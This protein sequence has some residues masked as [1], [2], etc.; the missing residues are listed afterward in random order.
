MKIKLVVLLLLVSL[1]FAPN[2]RPAHATDSKA[3]TARCVAGRT[4]PATGFW[5]W[6]ANSQVNVYL[7]EPD[8]SAADL[9][10]VEIAVQNWDVTA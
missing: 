6:P 4:A 9:A 8:F 1:A 5:T 3:I 10:P 7:R 2:L